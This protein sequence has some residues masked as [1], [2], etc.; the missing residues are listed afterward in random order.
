MARVRIEIHEEVVNQILNVNEVPD[1]VRSTGRRVLNRARVNTPVDQGDM[2]A[3]NRMDMDIV[4]FRQVKA[5]IS[6]SDEA[7]WWVNRG[8]GVHNRDGSTGP[9]RPRTKKFLKFPARKYPSRSGWVYAK[10]VQG[11]E[12]NEFLWRALIGGTAMDVQVWTI[13]KHRP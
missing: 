10:Q 9:I 11:Q 5:T 13:T 3:A 12:A 8:T 1:L 2:L 4:P 7:A 6:N